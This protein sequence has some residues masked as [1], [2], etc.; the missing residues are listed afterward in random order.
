MSRI[1]GAS[2]IRAR[3]AAATTSWLPVAKLQ[4]DLYKAVKSDPALKKYPVWTIS[5]NGA[6]TDNVGLQ[7]LTI[8]TG[9]NGLM[10]DGTR[11]ADAANVH[12]YIYHPNSPGLNDNKTWNAADPVPACKVD[13]L[14]GD[15]GSTWAH[16]YAGYSNA[17]C[18]AAAGH[19]GDRRDHRRAVTEES[20]P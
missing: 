11:Y 17:H 10:P 19:H 5:E 9:A 18:D 7:F 12:N 15:Y 3:P 4:R 14:Y 13:G 20:T 1:T 16:H 8:P 2:L 6:E